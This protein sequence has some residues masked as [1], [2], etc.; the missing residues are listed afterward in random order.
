[1]KVL[2][3]NYSTL[4]I[5]TLFVL[6]ACGDGGEKTSE[7]PVVNNTNSAIT[8][9]TRLCTDHQLTSATESRLKEFFGII[10][11]NL[12][13]PATFCLSID[14]SLG[15]N[16]VKAE[17][18]LEYEDDRGIRYYT[19]GAAETYYGTYDDNKLEIVWVDGGGFVQIKATE[20]AS[21]MMVGQIKYH[22]FSPFEDQL[23]AAAA[24]AA[25][26][27]KKGTWTV[28]ECL[29]Y[30]GPNTQWWNDTTYLSPRQ[31]LLNAA[32]AILA[33]STKTKVLSDIE[34]DLAAALQ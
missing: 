6:G 27:C 26:K 20:N 29:G 7:N 31:Q 34:F 9:I 4:L 8:D 25:A 19:A 17:L 21:G 13:G 16:K 2:N 5:G 10:V 32:K 1:M 33:D 23:A 22:N 15:L 30:Q 3:S 18:R 28:A 12:E 24:E 14:D 11:K